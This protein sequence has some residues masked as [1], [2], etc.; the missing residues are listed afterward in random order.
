MLLAHS[1]KH[2]YIHKVM[3]SPQLYWRGVLL[4]SVS[5]G[6]RPQNLWWGRICGANTYFFLGGGDRI[7]K[8]ILLFAHAVVTGL[9][10]H[11]QEIRTPPLK[12]GAIFLRISPPGGEYPRNIAP[13]GENTLGISPPFRIFD[14]HICDVVYS[15]NFVIL[16]S[17]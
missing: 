11:P 5:G 6:A 10:R 4:V 16:S 8:M 13:R 1:R 2:S 12:R 15:N 14:P 3:I 9:S 7:F 17:Y